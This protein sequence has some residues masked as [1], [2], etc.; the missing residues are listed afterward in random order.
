VGC[1]SRA[2]IS[3]STTSQ[4]CSI[5]LR[6]GDCGGHFSTVNSLSCSGN[7]FKMILLEV[8]IRG[9]VHGGQKRDGHG[10][11][12]CSGRPWHLNNAQLALRGL[13]CAKKTS[14]HHY[15]TTTSLHSGNKACWIHVLIL[16]TPNSDSILN[17]STEIETHQTKQH[18]SSLQPSNFGELLQSVASFFICSGDEW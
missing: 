11:K 10:Q 15:T 5:G 1:T 13:K 12:Q 4:R 9:W 6:C 14:P 8:A 17:V 2:R 7:Q 16:F 3:C 18:C